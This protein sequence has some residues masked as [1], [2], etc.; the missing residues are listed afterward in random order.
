[1]WLSTHIQLWKWLCIKWYCKYHH[2]KILLKNSLNTK[3][4][5][6]LFSFSS[7]EQKYTFCNVLY[8]SEGVAFIQHLNI[9]VQLIKSFA[10]EFIIFHFFSSDSFLVGLHTH[11]HTVVCVL[12][13]YQ[14]KQDHFHFPTKRRPWR[15]QTGKIS[16]EDSRTNT[17]RSIT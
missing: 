15:F 13:V 1:M 8:K 5:H 3:I 11:R 12:C 14:F 6:S 4:F 17:K 7:L 16:L 2:L 9:E 10:C